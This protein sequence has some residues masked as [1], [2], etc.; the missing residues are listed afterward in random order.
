[1]AVHCV[2]LQWADDDEKEP[3]NNNGVTALDCEAVPSTVASGA[4]SRSEYACTS[5]CQDNAPRKYPRNNESPGLIGQEALCDLS[6]KYV[7]C[8][9]EEDSMACII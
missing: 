7:E 2:P 6:Q 1:M 8:R 4:W 3:N 9:M 5:A